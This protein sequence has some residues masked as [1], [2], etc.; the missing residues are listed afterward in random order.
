[1]ADTVLPTPHTADV[2]DAAR[3]GTSK[4]TSWAGWAISS[5]TNKITAAKGEIQSTTNGSPHAV[6][7]LRSTSVPGPAKAPASERLGT[8][9]GPLNPA[10]LG[11][12]RSSSD[13]PPRGMKVESKEEPDEVDDDAWGASAWGTMT[14][15]DHQELSGEDETFFDA[16]A[17]PKAT[18]RPAPE[19]VPVAFDD[20]G[21]PDF[22]GWLAAQSKAKAKK[23][24]TKSSV[25][26]PAST[27]FSPPVAAS[28][29]AS[30]GSVKP[31]ASV[32]VKSINT[33]PKDDGDDDGW[34]DAW[35]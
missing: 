19:P 5:F 9:K 2:N 30:S 17:S 3:I 22:A 8:S 32:P 21:E 20:G 12:A 34:G 28:R 23:P 6:D 35:D 1:M 14:E 16:V 15:D 13:Q 26:K 27:I 33:K 29:T 10:A 25:S 7:S 4:D 11:L 24:F 31:K 18:S